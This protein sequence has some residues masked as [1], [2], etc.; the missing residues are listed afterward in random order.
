MTRDQKDLVPSYADN[1]HNK[2]LIRFYNNKQE[3]VRLNKW[4]KEHWTQEQLNEVVLTALMM[5]LGI[6]NPTLEWYYNDD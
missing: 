1:C 6:F 4:R 2:T 5:R 3:L